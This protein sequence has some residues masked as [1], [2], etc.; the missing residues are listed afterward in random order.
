MIDIDLPRYDVCRKWID[1]FVEHGNNFEDAW[2][3]GKKTESELEEFLRFHKEN[4]FWPEEL[5]T[6]LWYKI[7][8]AKKKVYYIS[9]ELDKLR[10]DSVL[11]DVDIDSSVIIPESPRSTWQLYKQRLINNR[12]SKQSIVDIENASLGILRRLSR[13][14]RKTEPIKGLVIGHVQSGKTANMAGLMAMAGD[15]GWNFFIILSGTIENLRKQTQ[16]RILNDLS[17][18]GLL[19]W[20]GLE[21][22]SK[23]CTHV[24][25][26]GYLQFS[27]DSRMRYFTV[28]LKNSSRLKKLINWLHMNP[29]A[30]SKMK[31]LVIDDEADQAGINTADVTKGER[32]TINRLIV[33]LV[34]G[35]THKGIEPVN[36]CIAMNYISYT[37]T[38]YANFLNESLPESLY[39]RHFIYSLKPATEYFGPKQIFGVEGTEYDGM[40]IISSINTNDMLAIKEIH[41]GKDITIPESMKEALCWF[42]C[43][44]AAMRLWNRKKPISMLVHTSMKQHHHSFIAKAIKKWIDT[45]EVKDLIS[46][47]RKVWI[48]KSY[49]ID[50]DGLKQA[51]PEFGLEKEEIKGYPTFNEIIDYIP[52]LISEITHIPLNG[53]GDLQ[54]KSHLHLCIDNCSNNGVD[55]DGMYVRLAY[56]EPDKKPYPTPAPAFIVIGG[57]TLSR[58]LTLEGLVC[59]YFTRNSYQGDSLMQMGRWFGFRRGY[60]LLPRLW[61]GEETIKKFEFLSTLEDELRSDLNRFMVLGAKPSE[62]GPKVK[63]SP[64]TL[65]L[66]IT[67]SK[68]MQSA[69]E[70]NV[71]YSGVSPQTIVFN[72]DE[73]TL[74]K[75]IELTDSFI[76]NLGKCRTSLG[77]N[78]IYWKNIHFNGNIE[79]YLENFN[80]SDNNRVF[81]QIETLIEWI[82]A[83][84]MEGRIEN[85]SVIVSG[86]GNINDNMK[87]N[88]WKID[89]YYVGKVNRSKKNTSTNDLLNIGVLRN[90][91]DLLADF[92]DLEF[93]KK[94]GIVLNKTYSLDQ[95]NNFRKAASL[96]KIPQLIIYKIDKRSKAEKKSKTRQSLD[97]KCD[98]IG[99]C[100][101]LPGSSVNKEG[102]VKA[103]TISIE[104]QSQEDFI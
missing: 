8:N 30:F 60:E 82:K 17:G 76:S 104:K 63:N 94:N 48:K 18:N 56:P 28:C 65:R 29:V 16:K 96:D 70:V 38:P 11:T 67:S 97:A 93:I 101:T 37:A 12:W 74:N 92:E 24:N 46:L 44:A 95:V 22:L 21:H 4:S 49:E 34:E 91:S 81:N 85:W 15:W 55:E 42:F 10:T 71:D 35:R 19:T 23:K 5:N 45:N 36:K 54:Y 7:F 39:P 77:K 75:N 20:Q 40:N 14:T 26:P 31:I 84:T 88:F 53:E 3:A 13:D 59:T 9:E 57:N 89:R 6:S 100:I 50:F 80:F 99:L 103:Y 86:K 62:Y 73:V 1:A 41:N 98:I 47:C 51:Y 66:R 102:K 78:S 68:K 32:R 72:N 43:S 69:I 52:S 87:G 25:R 58:G 79:K 90:P 64:S 33:N 61:M 27:D 2:L 83:A